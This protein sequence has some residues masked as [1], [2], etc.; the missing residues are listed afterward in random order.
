MKR[1]G[2]KSISRNSTTIN[3][4]Q[5]VK[6]IVDGFELDANID[7][8]EEANKK[9]LYDQWNEFVNWVQMLPAPD[10]APLELDDSLYKHKSAVAGYR[11]KLMEVQ[12][13]NND[14]W[15]QIEVTM[16]YVYPLMR[17]LF[18]LGDL[19]GY[20]ER[21]INKQKDAYGKFAY[22]QQQKL[23]GIKWKKISLKIA[24]N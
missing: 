24:N 22:D 11:T 10:N 14:V 13:I 20:L 19:E 17:R 15:N 21:T 12:F 18:D 4:E 7:T 9:M 3:V 8:S 2:Q 23:N 6:E 1:S 5:L 16:K